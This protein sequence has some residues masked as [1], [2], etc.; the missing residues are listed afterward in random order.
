MKIRIIVVISAL[1]T[2]LLLV[3]VASA[4][5]RSHTS[6][7]LDNAGWTCNNAGPHNW[8]HCFTPGV[9]LSSNPA[10]VQVKVFGE[11][12]DPFL[13][14]EILIRADLYGGQPCPQDGGGPYVLIAFPFGDYNAC[15]HFDTT[16]P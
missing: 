8:V 16:L 10:T 3:S 12:G 15:H 4:N 1:A 14:A 7:Q 2:L 11:K 6:A 5:G 13:G 9:D